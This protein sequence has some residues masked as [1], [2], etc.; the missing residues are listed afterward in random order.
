[1]PSTIYNNIK[2]LI[3]VKNIIELNTLIKLSIVQDI[4]TVSWNRKTIEEGTVFL[5]YYIE[6]SKEISKIL[7]LFSLF[8]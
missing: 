2:I 7:F 8:I 1:M 6:S 3:L 4:S 5:S